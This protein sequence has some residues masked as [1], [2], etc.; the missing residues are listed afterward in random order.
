MLKKLHFKF[1][2]HPN[3]A[4]VSFEPGPMTVLVGPNNSGKSLTLRE[5]HEVVSQGPTR[6]QHTLALDAIE[7]RYPE[8]G[9]LREALSEAIRRDVAPIQQSL[10][11]SLASAVSMLAHQS[12]GNDL[13]RFF[14][15]LNILD[16]IGKLKSLSDS[17]KLNIRHLQAALR[18]PDRYPE[19][20]DV[21]YILR[22]GHAFLDGLQ[23]HLEL[24]EALSLPEH[25]AAPAEILVTKQFI[26]L[27]GYL[28]KF[29]GASVLLDGK[30]RLS[31]TDAKRTHTL[32]NKAENLPMALRGSPD[33][34]R[35]L[36]AYVFEAF[37][38]HISIDV[39]SMTEARF[40]L[41]DEPPG[42]HEDSLGADAVDYF[43]KARDIATFSDGVKSYIGLHA[44]LLAGDHKLIL[45]DEPEAF[46]HPP[47]ARRLGYN[48][49]KLAV[50]RRASIVAATHSP[51]FL[52]GC[53]E[54]G[55]PLNVVRLGYQD[56]Q[57]RARL[58]PA[59]QLAEMMKSPLL[60]S[61]GVLEALFHQ[62]AI[63]CEGDSDRAFYQE[64]HE[65]LQRERY[66]NTSDGP[67]PYRFARDCIFLNSHGTG[68]MPALLSALHRVGIPTAAI[69][70]LDLLKDRDPSV[71]D[72]LKAVGADESEYRSINNDRG[73]KYKA[74]EKV[75]K[76]NSP[77]ESDLKKI[78]EATSRLIKSG[79]I[80]NLKSEKTLR[81][82]QTFLDRLAEYG[83]FAVPVGEL[84][85]WLPELGNGINKQ[86]WVP[87]MF[88]K[89]GIPGA[90]DYLAPGMGDVW[91][92]IQQVTDWL[93]KQANAVPSSTTT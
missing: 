63:I 41:A 77:Q 36:R 15:V 31:L 48:L 5:L 25:V 40:V 4:P 79:G 87:E 57:G 61:T 50:E 2:P 6:Y 7:L 43:A 56:G 73:E 76:E 51:A 91:E 37:G 21:H 53:V 88:K 10:G 11:E 65:R 78:K 72:F 20:S 67:A 32:R 58:L 62:S 14:Q 42:E 8:D 18:A 66:E 54:A 33:V 39:T 13:G 35:R 19:E 82:I 75:A 83:L 22:L 29:R 44:A 3:A 30:G 71:A 86:D 89:M 93:E 52:M 16:R 70:D 34:R 60:R 90:E 28:D 1:G 47:L 12:Q 27:E 45:I 24:L 38:K 68:S 84:E 26:R 74:F 64:I 80:R 59:E 92:F 55:E 9:P 69:L 85:S 49:T 81:A 46:L 17:D 23:A